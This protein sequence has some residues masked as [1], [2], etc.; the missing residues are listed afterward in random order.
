MPRPPALIL[1]LALLLASG[2][3]EVEPAPTDLDGLLHYLWRH[4]ETGS[5]EQL[6][7][8]VL[9]LHDAVGGAELQDTQD[10]SLSDL[11]PDDAALVGRDDVDSTQAQ[12][13]YMLRPFGCD[14]RALES[15][16]IYLPQDELYPSSYDSYERSYSSSYDEYVS[17]DS[18][19][20]TWEVVYG[21]TVIGA[22]YLG[23]VHGGIRS[24]PDLGAELTPWGPAL[25]TRSYMPEPASF[26]DDE[27]GSLPQDYQ[28]E[29]YYERA[30]DEILHA[31]GMWRQADF[32]VFGTTADEGIQRVI[33]NALADWDDETEA[34]CA[35]GLP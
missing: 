26:D 11:D 20:L 30:S 22:G 35:A 17:G 3:R 32:G 21:A 34:N 5:D 33:L 4:W 2:C 10:G 6:A 18:A 8:A 31:Y 24:L 14:L 13:M 15:I 28:V 12:G 19:F 29:L 1:P 16:L 23:Q 7:E 25:I 9:N 27:G